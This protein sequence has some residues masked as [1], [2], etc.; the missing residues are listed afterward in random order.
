MP[1]LGPGGAV[2]GAGNAVSA[3]QAAPRPSLGRAVFES[4]HRRVA[5]SN[6][7]AAE[8]ATRCLGS[9]CRQHRLQ[10][11]DVTSRPN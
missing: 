11:R 7:A 6:N 10:A 8:L 1:Y 9:Q 4:R 5:G 2:S 3:V